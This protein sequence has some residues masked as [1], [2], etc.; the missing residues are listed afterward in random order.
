MDLRHVLCAMYGRP[1]EPVKVTSL[2]ADASTRRYH[3]VLLPAGY[4]PSRL[5]VMELPHD[6]LSSDEATSGDRPHKLPFVDV[7]EHLGAAGLR[8]PTI[9]LDATAS[10]LVLLEDLGETLLLHKVAEADEGLRRAWYSAA[11]ELLVQMHGRMWPVPSTCVAAARRFDYNLLRWELDHYREWGAEALLGHKLPPGLRVTLDERFDALARLIADLPLGFVH[12]D[13]QSRNLM[14][15]GDDPRAQS[16][17]IIDFQ[18]AFV[19]PRIYDLVALLNDSYVE[20]SM[21]FKQEMVATYAKLVGLEPEVALREFLLVTVQ[22]KL[23]DGGRFVFIDR[24]RGNPSFLKFVD[25]SL[26]R[27]TEALELVPQ[28]G[29]LREVLLEIDPLRFG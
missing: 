19:G 11:V 1:V 29:A 2:P 4:E 23:K 18:D 12:R 10:G 20:L 21:S 22:R 9:Y 17:A 16:L 28:L 26:R 13:Y 25:T 5:F 24:V 14:V 27:V 8:V 7:A 3:R 15:V 6:A